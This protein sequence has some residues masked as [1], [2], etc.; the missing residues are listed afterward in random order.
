MKFW[1][2]AFFVL[3]MCQKWFW[4]GYQEYVFCIFGFGGLVPRPKIAFFDF[5]THFLPKMAFFVF[6]KIVG[7]FRRLNFTKNRKNI[8]IYVFFVIFSDFWHFWVL[9]DRFLRVPIFYGG[10]FALREGV[11]LSFF[12]FFHLK[13]H[14]IYKNKNIFLSK[15]ETCWGPSRFNR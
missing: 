4:G 14:K 8:K 5:L 7:S 9:F 6:L 13:F 1:T 15:F 2:N 11:F 10:I 3:K 12:M